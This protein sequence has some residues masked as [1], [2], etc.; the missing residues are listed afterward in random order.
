MDRLNDIVGNF[1]RIQGIVGK[2]VFQ[3]DGGADITGNHLL[4]FF[5]VFTIDDKNL[6][7]RS[8]TVPVGVDHIHRFGD[9][10]GINLEEGD[11]AEV[12]LRWRF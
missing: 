1:R 7:K 3:F 4:N 10:A 12:L 9:L 5:A 2:G 8:L 6:R 11:F